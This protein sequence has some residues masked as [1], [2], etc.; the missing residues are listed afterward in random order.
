MIRVMHRMGYCL[1]YHY[2]LTP[3]STGRLNGTFGYVLVTVLSGVTGIVALILTYT[4]FPKVRL[5]LVLNPELQK[6]L[7]YIPTIPFSCLQIPIS[8]YHMYLKP[9]QYYFL[10][11][12]CAQFLILQLK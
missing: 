4:N 1:F 2:L 12:E 10:G 11:S 8:N 5:T 7:V 3:P 6:E 9:K